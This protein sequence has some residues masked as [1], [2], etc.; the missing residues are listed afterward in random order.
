MSQRK[1]WPVDS[2]SKP[3]WLDSSIEIG[4]MHVR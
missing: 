2:K 1:E 4:K 3:G